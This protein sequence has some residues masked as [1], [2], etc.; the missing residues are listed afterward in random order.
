MLY[1]QRVNK[2]VER[3]TQKSAQLLS[4]KL[5]KKWVHNIPGVMNWLARKAPAV[6]Q[7]LALQRALNYTFKKNSAAGELDFFNGKHLTV[8]ITD[9]D[10]E[11]TLTYRARALLVSTVRPHVDVRFAAS[12]YDLLLIATQKLDPDMLFFQ[13]R[14]EMSGDTELGLGIKNLL[15]SIELQQQV[16]VRLARALLQFADMVEQYRI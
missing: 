16:N 8:A 13:R 4:Q 5:A 9:I 3:L 15:A 7:Q 12:S 10:V 1:Q 2:E 6:V 11:F 14:L